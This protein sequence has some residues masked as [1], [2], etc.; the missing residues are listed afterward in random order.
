MRPKFLNLIILISTIVLLSLPAEAADYV[1]IAN[2]SVSQDSLDHTVLRNIYLGKRTVWPNGDDII[3]VMLQSGT[4]REE[5]L[6]TV[7]KKSDYQFESY[8]KQM[9]FTGKGIPLKNFETL[10]EL[11]RFVAETPG[12]IGYAPENKIT[13]SVKRIFID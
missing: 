13:G 11:V 3:P 1:I 12:A 8:W 4:L 10:D 2:N 9:I 6:R 7:L 5:F